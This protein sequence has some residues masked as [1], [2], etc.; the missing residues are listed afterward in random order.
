VD[1]NVPIEDTVGE[2]SRLQQ[3]G[4]VRYLGLSEAAPRTIRAAHATVQHVDAA[5]VL[6]P[7]TID[8]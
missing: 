8:L 5:T 1:P 6:R 7:E 4:K 3:E 2:M